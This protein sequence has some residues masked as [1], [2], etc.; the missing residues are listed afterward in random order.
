MY[1]RVVD[2]ETFTNASSRDVVRI[3]RPSVLA[4][5]ISFV[6]VRFAI[7]VISASYFV[8]RC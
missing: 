2:S 6:A 1:I 7:R 3:E 8:A 5:A 4:D